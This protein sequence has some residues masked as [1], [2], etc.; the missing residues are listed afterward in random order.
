MK[1]QAQ[2]ATQSVMSE[3]TQMATRRLWATLGLELC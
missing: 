3:V 2:S 1:K